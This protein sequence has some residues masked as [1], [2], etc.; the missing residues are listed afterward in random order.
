MPT[1]IAPLVTGFADAP[2][3]TVELYSTGTAVLSSLVY[4]DPHGITPATTHP[5]DSAGRVVRYVNEIV[6]VV[7]K[8]QAGVQVAPTFT[9]VVD[10]RSVRVE[11]TLFTGPNTNGNG[12]VVAGGRTTLHGGLTLLRSSLGTTDGF[13]RWDDDSQHSLQTA[14]RHGIRKTRTTTTTLAGTSYTP[15]AYYH[16]HVIVHSSGASIAIANPSTD[17]DVTGA[18]MIIVYV[19]NVGA[20]R[21]P[22]WGTKYSGAPA[23][24]VV[25]AT[26]AVYTFKLV[27]VNGFGNEW[28]L[29][30]DSP[31]TSAA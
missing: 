9:Q 28:V 7:V 4:S 23:T 20:D 3:G 6:D 22:T 16:T 24:A 5:L 21:T 26:T 10:A 2:N 13:V 11:N 27:T 25:T 1:L 30:T 15:N 12:Q 19:N 17:W 29:V 14:V 8:N 31:V 18:E